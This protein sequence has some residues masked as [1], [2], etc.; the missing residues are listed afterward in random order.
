MQLVYLS[1]LRICDLR[2]YSVCATGVARV[3]VND[4]LFD[5]GLHH[6]IFHRHVFSGRKPMVR[7]AGR[8]H[9]P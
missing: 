8:W 2:R 3:L 5:D 1:Y 4:D 6:R 9:A 7:D